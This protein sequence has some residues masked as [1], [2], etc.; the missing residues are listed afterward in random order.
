[1]RQAVHVE[2]R[3]AGAI[4]EGRAAGRPGFVDVLHTRAKR[5]CGLSVARRLT[6]GRSP[7]P[8]TPF[9]AAQP[10]ADPDLLVRVCVSLLEAGVRILAIG[11]RTHPTGELSRTERGRCH[12][13]M[14]DVG[15]SGGR[16]ALHARGGPGAAAD[17]EGPD[18]DRAGL[19]PDPAA[20]GQVLVRAGYRRR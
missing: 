4:C 7:I 19:R 15:G 5:L 11:T 13:E 8:G 16:R 20:R 14:A 2:S 12:V 3:P 10:A 17:R 1:H 18:A 9:A 6:R